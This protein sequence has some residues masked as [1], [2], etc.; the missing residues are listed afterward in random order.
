VARTVATE[1]LV[2]RAVDFG[3]ADR[4]LTL[5]T[6]DLG[7]LSAMARGARRSRRRFGAALEPFAVLAVEVA[8]GG[9]EVGRLVSASLQRAFPVLL[10][11]LHRLSLAGRMLACVRAA[12]PPGPADVRL[13]DVCVEALVAVDT[14]PRPGP[15]LELA[16]TARL[17]ALLGFSPRLDRCAVCGAAA[18]EGRAALFD[19]RRT[20][21]VCRACGGGPLRLSGRSRAVLAAAGTGGWTEIGRVDWTDDVRAEVRRVL[22]AVLA[23]HVLAR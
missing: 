18:P 21:V 23:A 14:A 6:R 16:F 19:P 2:L 17:C 22:D 12:V 8:P 13:F 15:E 5:L 11:D 10:G 3:E 1:A 7:R 20:A 9:G 4:I